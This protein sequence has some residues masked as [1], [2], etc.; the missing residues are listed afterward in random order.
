MN[1][2]S[3]LFVKESSRVYCDEDFIF[4]FSILVGKIV[5]NKL[6]LEKVKRFSDQCIVVHNVYCKETERFYKEWMKSQG[7][8]HKNLNSYVNIE[9]NNKVR[10][11]FIYSDFFASPN[12]DED[13]RDD[14]KRKAWELSLENMINRRHRFCVINNLNEVHISNMTDIFTN[15]Y[16]YRINRFL[17]EKSKTDYHIITINTFHDCDSILK[18]ISN[19]NYLND[20]IIV[21]EGSDS[22]YSSLI[23]NNFL[24]NISFRSIS[25]ISK[26]D[27]HAAKTTPNG[28]FFPEKKIFFIKK[29]KNEKIIKNAIDRWS[30]LYVCSPSCY[31]TYGE[32]DG[33]HEEMEKMNKLIKRFYPFFDF[34]KDKDNGNSFMNIDKYS[35][36]LFKADIVIH[37]IGSEYLKSFYCMRELVKTLLNK[38]LISDSQTSSET[39]DFS[40]ITN[41]GCIPLFTKEA[42]EIIFENKFDMLSFWENELENTSFPKEDVN[43]IVKLLP[44]A[45]DL[46]NKTYSFKTLE[47]FSE[48]DYV[49]IFFFLGKALNNYSEIGYSNIYSSYQSVDDFRLMA[50][51]I[52]KSE[53]LLA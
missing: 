1:E 6:A 25:I 31:F 29:E 37:I 16:Q 3:V 12:V 49:D 32:K 27:T 50:R 41:Y 20:F 10:K 30:K 35:N 9:K 28:F 8:I 46:F 7:L 5:K 43:L 51:N 15:D 18:F 33:L 45:K 40:N 11:P 23:S 24:S 42:K 14:V 26:E 13:A 53:M 2:I 39:K 17:K 4:Y 22:C 44:Q 34:V 48:E 52:I 38:G 36:N 19:K 21:R 47:G